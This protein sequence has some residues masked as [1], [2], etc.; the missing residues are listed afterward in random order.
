M[1]QK[2]GRKVFAED[3][4][5]EPVRLAESGTMPIAQLA[6]EFKHPRRD[7]PWLA[8]A[9]AAELGTLHTPTIASLGAENRRL[10]RELAILREEREI[11]RGRGFN[12]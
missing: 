9:S 7:D 2:R 8:T 3:F 10:Q 1:K 4:R 5:R 12:R 11:K 6:Q